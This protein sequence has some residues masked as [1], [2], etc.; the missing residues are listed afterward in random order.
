M[1]LDFTKEIFEMVGDPKKIVIYVGR[2]QPFHINHFEA[3]KYLTDKFGVDNVYISTSNKVEEKS[4]FNFKEKQFIMNKM[5]N[6]PLDK[7]VENKSPYIAINITKNFIGKNAAMIYA[8]GEKDAQRLSQ[9]KHYEMYNDNLDLD[10]NFR[11]KEYIIVIP[12]NTVKYKFKGKPIYGELVREVFSDKKK[13]SDADRKELLNI[14]YPYD[15]K[16]KNA[17]YNL[18]ISKIHSLSENKQLLTC[19]GAFGHVYHPF[20]DLSL[21][22]IDVKNMIKNGFKGDLKF[23]EE[24]TDGQSLLISWKNGKLISARNKS[25][26][27]NFGENALDITGLSKMFD[28]RGS[29]KDA[30]IYAMSDLSN[31]ISKLSEMDRI[32][33]FDE[34]K[35]FMSVEVIY[36]STE[37][38]IPYGSSMLIFHGTIEYDEDGNVIGVFNKSEGQVLTNL[39]KQVNMDI[40]N[41]YNISPANVIKFKNA[42][43]VNDQINKFT[44]ELNNIMKSF[45]LK[46]SDTIASMLKIQ[47]IRY[48][49]EFAKKYKYNINSEL[50][51]KL[52]DKLSGTN[53]EY[54]IKVLKKDIDNDNF[55][56]EFDVIYKNKDNMNKKFMYPLE[57]FILKMGVQILKNI[58]VFLAANPTEASS[59]MK[60]K[61]DSTIHDVESSNDKDKLERLQYQMKRF[62]DVGGYDSILPTEGIVFMF[63]DKLYKLTG[64]FAPINNILALKTYDKSVR[65]NLTEGGNIKGVTSSVLKI[66]SDSTVKNAFELLDLNLTYEIVG[67]KYKEVSGD[68]DCGIESTDLM[69][70]LS[71]TNVDDMWS[72]LEDVV[73]NNNLPYKLAK[74]LRQI[75]IVVPMVDNNGNNVGSYNALGEKIGDDG[76][77]QLDLFIG[78]IPWMKDALGYV[79]GSK[80]KMAY[81]NMYLMEI[82]RYIIFNIKNSELKRKLQFNWKEGVELVDFQDINGKRVK[83][84]IKKVIGDMNKLSR[85]LFTP[86]YSFTNIDT[87]EK[88]YNAVM[89]T[90]FKFKIVRDK[91]NSEFKKTLEKMKLPVPQE[92]E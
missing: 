47:W 78:N 26:L 91:I 92:M 85:F 48:L 67:N 1:N 77:I 52:V 82:L 36:P 27:R 22:F 83:L 31:A 66:Y 20:E 18:F 16:N 90:E 37:N 61:L 34:G 70:S 10:T 89:S 71:A 3:Y 58:T 81:R 76:Q 39:I 87:F 12:S 50:L 60:N 35:K 68:I 45:S 88:L 25:H 62:N 14:L 73:K 17:L 86:K 57:I 13:Y 11:E 15:K 49:S 65:E 80:Y 44:L 41:H 46:D 51:T 4:P 29:I 9:S 30:F 40:Q 59:K 24:K 5:F 75:S 69:K 84:S 32:S 43:N 56:N 33:L 38:V 8:L 19:G 79:E 2:F 6:I 42:V 21:T 63:N 72:K 55:K 53:N 23:S 64:S 54:N 28:G 7:I 74:G